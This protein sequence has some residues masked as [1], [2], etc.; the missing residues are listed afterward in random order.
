MFDACEAIDMTGH[1]HQFE[2]V[3]LDFSDQ[4]R[5][6]LDDLTGKVTVIW[7]SRMSLRCAET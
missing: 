2:Q 1:E 5:H 6:T 7:A 4:L 3:A